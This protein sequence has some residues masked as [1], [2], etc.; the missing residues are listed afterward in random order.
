MQ[1]ATRQDAIVRQR[2]LF[3]KRR[4]LRSTI[5]SLTVVTLLLSIAGGAYAQTLHSRIGAAASNTAVTTYKGNNF[6]TGDYPNETILNTSNV[7]AT[8]FGSRVSYP[9]DGQVYAQPLYVPNLTIN[10]ST[11]NIV[12]VETEHDSAY[13]FD[14][15]QRGSAIAPLWQR[16]FIDP[17]T[18]ITS[19][20][21]SAV[22]CGDITP[23]Y[24]ITGTPVINSRIHTMYVVVNT[25]ENGA[26]IYR[27]HALD[28]RTGADKAGSPVVITAKLKGAG[29]GNV[30][31]VIAFD[32]VREHQRGSLLL[33]NGTVYVTFGSHCDNDNYHGWIISYN[34]ATLKR[35]RMY[36]DSR[37]GTRAGIWGSGEGLSADTHGK[38]Y[39]MTGNGTFDLNKGGRDAGDSIVK[40]SSTLT[41]ESYFTPFNQSCL[42]RDDAD[43]GSGGVLLLPNRNE[44]IGIGK[45]GRIY[46]TSR[47]SLGGYNTIAG[48]P[49]SNQ[50]LT[51][52]D[53]VLQ[54][55]PPGTAAG[56]IWSTPAYWSGPTG[57][58]VYTI[59]TADTVKAF[60]LNK[61][62]LNSTPSS[63]S[64]ESFGYPGGNPVVSSNGATAGTGILW[65]IDPRGVL[66]AYDAT[67]LAT[68]LFS[69]NLPS[70]VKFSVPTVANGEV[71]VGTRGSLEIYGLLN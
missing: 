39:F 66:R 28:I 40:L 53:K 51:N 14:A 49:C 1:R 17:A 69:G 8:Q 6:R 23:E 43:L 18:G 58:F 21:S 36:N 57:E 29:A 62:L 52:V 16:S 48:D 42:E 27:L 9:V 59:G 56:G 50:G 64:P 10:G 15:D 41:R 4:F 67:N 13:A 12:F 33:L 45:E 32:P 61:G 25:L 34:A 68:E 5:V 60:K 54:E 63:A 71:F 30:N 44:L 65:T 7:N 26:N 3:S 38:I 37:D 2:S 46:V 70:Y 20:P 47:S 31:G 22:G 19:V 11:H 24:G 55:L 35:S